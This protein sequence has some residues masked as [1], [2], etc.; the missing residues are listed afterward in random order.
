MKSS[1]FITE[2][3]RDRLILVDFQ[4]AYQSDDFGYEDAI[5]QA[6]HYINKKQPQVTAF[7]NGGDV[8]IEDT[9]EEVMWHYMKHGLDEE[10][11]HLFT[12][13]EKSYGWLRSWMDQGVDHSTIIKVVR[14]MVM[15]DMNDSLKIGEDEL[16]KLVGDDG[17]DWMFDD[18]I[19]LPDISIGNLKQLSGSLLGGG[20]K[21]ECL[22]ELKLLMDAFNIKY[23][24]VNDWI[25]G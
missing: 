6:V 18:G 11:T 12:F 15:N 23:K 1:E 20:G 21:H 4:P 24:L 13:K 2:A 16:L 25:Y 17:G 9:E 22:E 5:K 14:Y 19:Y 7:F 10:L 3:R 8:S